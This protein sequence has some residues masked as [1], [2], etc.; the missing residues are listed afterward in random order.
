MKLFFSILPRNLIESFKGRVLIWHLIAI[1][2]TL[3]LVVSGFDWQYFLWTRSPLLRSWLYPAVPI[4]ALVPV[5]LPLAL[6]LLSSVTRNTQLRLAAWAISQAEI[7]GGIV[8]ASYKALTGRAH[9]SHEVATDVSRVFKFGLLRGGV[10]WGWPS[11]HTTIAF[12][13]AVTVFKLCPNHRW[14]GCLA[15]V[16]A[17]YI[18][19]GVSMTIHW[20]SDFAAGALIG[21]AVGIVVGDSFLRFARQPSAP[22][23]N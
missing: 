15:I 9:P 7:I 16:Y 20:L 13:M 11:S 19:L 1:V 2:S 6:F 17:F 14:L 10:F 23:D 18:G 12:A 5:A 22:R 21:T 4:G 8:A 3:A